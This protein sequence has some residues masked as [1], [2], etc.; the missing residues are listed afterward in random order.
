MPRLAAVIRDA[1][2]LKQADGYSD[3]G[4]GRVDE[5]PPGGSSMMREMLVTYESPV[6]IRPIRYWLLHIGIH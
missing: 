3:P 1:I 5:R 2:T 4:I 6:A